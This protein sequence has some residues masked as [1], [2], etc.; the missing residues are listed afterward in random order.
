MDIHTYYRLYPE[1]RNRDWQRCGAAMELMRIFVAGANPEPS[2][3]G[4]IDF[5]AGSLYI[6]PQSLYERINMHPAVYFDAMRRLQ[7]EGDITVTEYNY[8]RI[9]TLTHYPAPHPKEEAPT[10]SAPPSH[11]SSAPNQ[12]NSTEVG[13]RFIASAHAKH[14]SAPADAPW[15]VPTGLI[16]NTIGTR[17]GALTEA[18]V[19][20]A[21]PTSL[22][23]YYIHDNH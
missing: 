12:L 16:S 6:L 9:I 15:R 5:P 7:Y 23:I 13:T 18:E 10:P 20:F 8:N 2:K 21:R 22:S 11:S 1:L 19:T 4:G 17:H 3:I 14:T